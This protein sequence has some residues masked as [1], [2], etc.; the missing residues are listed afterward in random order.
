MWI[1]AL[2][3]IAWLQAAPARAES[4]NIAMT[5]VGLTNALGGVY[6]GPYTVRDTTT[7]DMFKVICDDFYD[8]TYVG[9]SWS[10]NVS[11]LSDLS[12]SL[13]GNV[14][15]SATK[16]N[17]VGW[18]ATQLFGASTASDAANI[19]FAL[20]Q[21]FDDGSQTNGFSPFSL[22]AG[23][24]NL[25]AAQSWLTQAQ[26]LASTF[27]PGQFSNI[28]LYTPTACISGC[29]GSLP[30]EFVGIR[31]VPEPGTLLLFGTGLAGLFF[32][33]RRA[34]GGLA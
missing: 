20:W 31:S 24:T 9:E 1:V 3:A 34:A 17:E 6:I 32:R 28:V 25:A 5:G 27:T 33:R 14:A 13:F 12:G 29:Y 2:L 7:G 30:Q 11:S 22:L 15:D 4:V 10:A 8:D 18:L 16:Y 23:T 26:T 21:V 19:Q